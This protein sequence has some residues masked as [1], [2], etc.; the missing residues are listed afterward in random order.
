MNSNLNSQEKFWKGAFGDKYIFR[1]N[2]K[3][4]LHNTDV[5]FKKIFKKNK[6]IKIK[7]L[8]ELGSNIGNNIISLSKILKNC[9]FT[10]VEINKKACEILKKKK[11]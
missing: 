8:I 6:K 5:F 1:N 4:L 7:N 9:N 10:A 11:N 2:S 3:K